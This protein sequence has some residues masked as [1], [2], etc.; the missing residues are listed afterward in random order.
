MTSKLMAGLMVMI[1][2]VCFLAP[3]QKADAQVIY[4]SYCCD[5]NGVRRC[6]LDEAAPIYSACF[7]RAQG[8]GVVCL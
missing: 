6:V 2:G 7:C 1:A 4:G 3:M 8:G 5:G